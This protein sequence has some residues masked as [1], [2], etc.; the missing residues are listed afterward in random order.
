M[1]REQNIRLART[2]HVGANFDFNGNP[3]MQNSSGG[4]VRMSGPIS[5]Y[6]CGHQSI[7]GI[8][9]CSCATY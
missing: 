1:E 6:A 5:T 9:A 8:D 7:P 3:I 2:R 4:I